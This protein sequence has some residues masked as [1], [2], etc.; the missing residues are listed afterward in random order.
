MP[1]LELPTTVKIHFNYHKGE[2]ASHDSPGEP[3]SITL[4]FVE[5]SSI[6]GLWDDN[7]ENWTI[8]E[9]DVWEARDEWKED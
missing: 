8:L 3:E 1:T 9:K 5:V 7:P 2:P 6:P 4:N